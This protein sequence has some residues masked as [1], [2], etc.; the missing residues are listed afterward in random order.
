MSISMW[1]EICV[2]KTFFEIPILNLPSRVVQNT[3]KTR[4]FDKNDN[5]TTFKMILIIYKMSF[6]SS[7]NIHTLSNYQNL[8]KITSK[9]WFFVKFDTNVFLLKFDTI[10]L[11]AK[12][13][14]FNISNVFDCFLALKRWKWRTKKQSTTFS[15]H[16]MGSIL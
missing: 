12:T 9:N 15:W 8:I 13:V 14:I 16:E 7:F 4:S 5:K 3:I 10:L 11:L 6:V 2:L 1:L